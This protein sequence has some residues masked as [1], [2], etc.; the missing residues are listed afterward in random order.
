MIFTIPKKYFVDLK[1]TNHSA[2]KLYFNLLKI[3]KSQKKYEYSQDQLGDSKI[4]KTI[5]EWTTNKQVSAIKLMKNCI[6]I[7][8]IA[9]KKHKQSMHEHKFTDYW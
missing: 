8:S 6:Y 2:W 5:S 7:L 9:T 3:T 1:E 4:G